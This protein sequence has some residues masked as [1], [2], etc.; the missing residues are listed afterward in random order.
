MSVAILHSNAAS[1]LNTA[2]MNWYRPNGLH[3]SYSVCTLQN[4]H[5]LSSLM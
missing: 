5:K 2:S 3:D 4:S 1:A